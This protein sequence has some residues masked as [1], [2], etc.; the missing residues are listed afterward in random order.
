MYK[1]ADSSNFIY[2]IFKFGDV[3][4]IGI[5]QKDIGIMPGFLPK[6]VKL[7]AASAESAR[8]SDAL[9][10]SEAIFSLA[11]VLVIGCM[12]RYAEQVLAVRLKVLLIAYKN[13]CVCTRVVS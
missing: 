8:D 10:R 9:A 11:N 4:V 7:S 6:V 3:G 1:Y 12:V 5:R 13:C 2:Y